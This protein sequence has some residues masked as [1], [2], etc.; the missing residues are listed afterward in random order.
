MEIHAVFMHNWDTE[1]NMCPTASRDYK[2]ALRTANALRIPLSTVNFTREYWSNVFEPMI[3]SLQNGNT[4]N[5]DI[6]CNQW[7]KF[8]AFANL[9]LNKNNARRSDHER[10]RNCIMDGINQNS[11]SLNSLLLEPISSGTID[12]IVTG[13]YARIKNDPT[14]LKPMLQRPIDLKKD[15]SYFLSTVS[16]AALAQTIFPLGNLCKSQVK[17]IAAR[18]G[19]NHVSSKRE[20]MGIC[21]IEPNQKFGDFVGAF[22]EHRPGRFITMDGVVKGQHSGIAKYTVGQRARISGES[23]KCNHEALFCD[24]NTKSAIG[25]GLAGSEPELLGTPSS[26]LNEPVAVSFRKSSDASVYIADF[27]N[28]GS[29]RSKW[30]ALYCGDICLGGGQIM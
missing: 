2:D 9:L 5:P 17:E 3:D 24:R 13:H 20:S 30:T 4:P 8:G 22:L 26:I 19:L 21:F 15:Q 14:S 6:G 25:F 1:G 27:Q 23:E 18:N 12:F 7:I 11:R 29:R 10:I 28:S 16:H